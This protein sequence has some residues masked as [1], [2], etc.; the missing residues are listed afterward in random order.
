MTNQMD[1]ARKV[2]L[3]NGYGMIKEGYEDATA[4]QMAGMKE[5][6]QNYIDTGSEFKIKSKS[7]KLGLVV[8]IIKDENDGWL[9]LYNSNTSRIIAQ[10]ENIDSMIKQIY[11]IQAHLEQYQK[12]ESFL[13][14]MKGMVAQALK[15]YPYVI[16]PNTDP[17][18]DYFEG[19]PD[20]PR[21]KKATVYL[22]GQAESD[23]GFDISVILPG[24]VKETSLPDDKAKVGVGIVTFDGV[25]QG[26]MMTWPLRELPERKTGLIVYNSDKTAIQYADKLF[27][28]PPR[29]F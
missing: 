16:I 21:V 22:H 12:E 29:V 20:I 5:R 24:T 26:T 28:N 4:T 14:D 3:K 27:M 15:E 11:D 9:I 13:L 17:F 7:N 18:T 10:A 6:L 8:N 23:A 1:E 25:K 2:L 19:N